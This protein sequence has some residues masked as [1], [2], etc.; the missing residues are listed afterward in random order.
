M[1][2]LANIY[3]SGRKFEQSLKVLKDFLPSAKEDNV[4]FYRTLSDLAWML[5]DYD[6]KAL[7]SEKLISLSKVDVA[8]YIM[9]SE[10]YFRKGSKRAVS[11]ALEG[12]KKFEDLILLK[13]A[14]YYSYALRL[15]DQTVAIFKDHRDKLQD[16]V[17][18]VFSYLLALQQL[19]KNEEALE[20]L[21]K[22]LAKSKTPEF[23]SFYIYSLVE[24]QR[25]D[26]LKRALKEYEAYTRNP[27]V[28]QAYAVA[29]IFL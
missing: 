5:Q 7:A 4:E 11:L 10:I 1:L 19:G 15:Y 23:V 26:E 6:A 3:Y 21:E 17:N 9:L 13:T 24:T 29:Y 18:T 25:V 8:D 2:L 14:S 27:S 16:D 12:Y 22:I 20:E 28:A